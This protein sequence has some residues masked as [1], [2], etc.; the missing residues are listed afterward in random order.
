M[1]ELRVARADG[2]GSAIVASKSGSGVNDPGFSTPVWSPDGNRLVYTVAG[3]PNF[4][5]LDLATGVLT[6]VAPTFPA[7]I[8]GWRPW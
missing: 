6:S 8:I 5:F 3:T 7:E 1:R 4:Q 2:T